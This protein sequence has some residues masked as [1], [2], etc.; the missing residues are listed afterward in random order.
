MLFFWFIDVGQ[1]PDRVS[2]YE[3]RRAD[4][5]S[6]LQPSRAGRRLRRD[7]DG[8]RIPHRIVHNHL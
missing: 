7:R 8:D 6:R 1:F 5:G 3:R 4:L 2:F